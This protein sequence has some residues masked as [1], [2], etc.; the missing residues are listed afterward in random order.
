MTVHQHRPNNGLR[1]RAADTKA[2]PVDFL[3]QWYRHGGGSDQEILETFGITS[4]EYFA[5]ILEILDD[6]CGD[7]SGTTV[8]AI[9]SVARRR[10]WLAS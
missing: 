1:N 2:T 6:E 10:L 3:T 7:L 4:R 9:R 8:A 5:H